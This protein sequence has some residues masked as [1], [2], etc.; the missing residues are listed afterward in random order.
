M[1]LTPATA[2][3][4]SFLQRQRDAP[5]QDHDFSEIAQHHVLGLDIAMH[6]AAGVC[7]GDR[8]G[9]LH[10]DVQVFAL[11]LG[12]DVARPGRAFHPLHAV[13]QR[14]IMV[15]AKVVDGD[16]IGMFQFARNNRF[17]KELDPLFLVFRVG[18]VQHLDRHRAINRSLPGRVDNP[19]AAFANDL[20]QLVILRAP[21]AAIAWCGR[22]SRGVLAFG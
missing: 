14:P 22:A 18:G 19:H 9:D 4:A 13:E 2:A 1:P 21:A 5:V 15:A 3:A 16:D 10:Q 6:D 12:L 11:R 8:V 7:E 20:Q 17:G